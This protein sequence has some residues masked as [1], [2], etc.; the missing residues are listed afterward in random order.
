MPTKHRQFASF[1]T[2]KRK[3]RGLSKSELAREVGVVRANVT[4]WEAGKFL[5]QPT[6]LERLARALRVSYEDLFVLAGY[7]SPKGLP[8]TEPYL[9][10]LY[11][12]ISQKR[13]S[14][15]KALFDVID[16]E[17]KRGTRAGTKGRRK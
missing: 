9:R 6:A 13:L 10:A 15:A 12:G 2:A 17:Q 1:I 4:F 16:A 11:P 14:E 3:Q 7:V 8:G 5:P